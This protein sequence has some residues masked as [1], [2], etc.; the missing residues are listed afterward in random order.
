MPNT[1]DFIP[2]QLTIQAQPSTDFIKGTEII[3]K[4]KYEPYSIGEN[5]CILKVTSPE[6]GE[7]AFVLKGVCNSP[8]AQGPYKVP[9]GKDYKFEFK[10]PLNEGA[11]IIVRFDNLNFTCGKLN[12]K[13][14]AKKTII[15]P[16]MF[17]NLGDGKTTGRMIITLNKLPPWI[18]YLQ[19]E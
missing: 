14:E 5:R 17:K 2:E 9:I 10:N 3:G 15:I 8:Q 6:G 19:A 11:E 13:I 1:S 18:I 16:I 7:Y 4:I 12:N